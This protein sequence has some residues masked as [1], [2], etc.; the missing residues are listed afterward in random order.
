M[1]LAPL[2][3]AHRDLARAVVATTLDAHYAGDRSRVVLALHT[4]DAILSGDIDGAARRLRT[5][6]Q[7][8]Q[9]PRGVSVSRPSRLHTGTARSG[10][11]DASMGKRYRGVAR[12][13]ESERS[14]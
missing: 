11:S 5:L 1:T 10:A 4:L 6:N 3:A 2:T 9:P 12:R 13:D 14:S 8:P 7:P